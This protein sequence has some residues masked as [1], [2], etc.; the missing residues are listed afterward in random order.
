LTNS[1]GLNDGAEY[2]PDGNFIY[3]NSSRTGTMQLWRMHPNGVDQEQVTDDQF[4]NWF[5]HISPDGKWIAFIS[6][7]K[8]VSP[9]DHPYYKQVYL[10]VMPMTGG[11]P[12]VIAYVYG[13]QGTMNVPSWSPDSKRIAL[14]SNSEMN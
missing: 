14:V 5:P 13:G 11:A 9:T 6:F 8:E 10:R 7:S 4:N 3:F 1:D 12:K 2:T